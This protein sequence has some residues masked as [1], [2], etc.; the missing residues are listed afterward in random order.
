MNYARW[1]CVYLSEMHQ[2]P[3]EVEEE[4]QLGNFVVKGSDQSF[5]QVDPDHSL[6]W[7]NGVGKKSGGIIGITKTNSALTRWTLSYN[8]RT[9][10]SM[11]TYEMMN[12]GVD[13]EFIP[14]EATS[15]RIK[16]DN[17]DEEHLLRILLR[18]KVFTEE[19]TGLPN[20]LLNCA[21]K[22]V[23]TSEIEESLLNA[24]KLGQRKLESFV[25]ERLV[26]SADFFHSALQKVK[27][28]TFAK[29]YDVA[30]KTPT[31]KTESTKAD[32]NFMQRLIAAYR[33]GRPV[34]LARIL[35]HELM[36]VPISIAETSGELRSGIKAN[37]FDILT[38]CVTCPTEISVEEPSCLVIDGQAAVMSF[39]KP[40][41]AN[42]F[43][44]YADEFVKF[45]FRQGKAYN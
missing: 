5:N 38:Q 39:G 30:T 43:G 24:E 17:S 9:R 40:S 36:N 35:N 1:G 12:V 42:T 10:I 37:L 21:T 4:F 18:F 27:A 8:H 19:S 2:L 33:A 16:R 20:K 45:I 28:P 34:D 31:V 13:T 29:L 32:R 7:L 15:S 26:S 11:Q 14:N 3:S 23:A 44:D 6:E 41:T 25:E 22:D